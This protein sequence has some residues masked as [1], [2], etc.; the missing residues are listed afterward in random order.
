MENPTQG[1]ELINHSLEVLQHEDGVPEYDDILSADNGMELEKLR[2]IGDD[3]SAYND[4]VS[5]EEGSLG[6][7]LNTFSVAP[8]GLDS[9]SLASNEGS[10]DDSANKA[11]VSVTWKG[12][13]YTSTVVDGDSKRRDK[14]SS[15]STSL[16]EM[17][18]ASL[19]EM[20]S[21]GLSVGGGLSAG[22]GAKSVGLGHSLAS[23]SVYTMTSRVKGGVTSNCSRS[24]SKRVK[25]RNFP[26]KL[27]RR[28]P[29]GMVGPRDVLVTL[30]LPPIQTKEQL[31]SALER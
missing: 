4:S 31:K 23:S 29:F 8:G 10:V 13:V 15:F 6:S 9:Y 18:S 14:L 20:P 21:V 16:S 25:P 12:K 30:G 28:G 19:S 22:G 27:R 7:T 5:F 26:K 17:P 1:L 3:M 11:R 24:S 2:D